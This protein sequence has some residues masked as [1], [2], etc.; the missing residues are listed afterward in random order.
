MWAEWAAN[1][2]AGDLAAAMQSDA[3]LSSSVVLR[4][5][6]EVVV[7]DSLQQVHL[8]AWIGT[9]KERAQSVTCRSL[10]HMT[11]FSNSPSQEDCRLADAT[12]CVASNGN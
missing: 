12:M 4:S 8:D 1:A 2:L 3:A 6:E 9:S 10:L 5:W 11:A 7:A